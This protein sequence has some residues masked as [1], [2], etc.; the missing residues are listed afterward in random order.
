MRRAHNWRLRDT[1]LGRCGISCT[2]G[3]PGVVM[4]VAAP[5]VRVLP[6]SIGS[7]VRLASIRCLAGSGWPTCPLRRP[8]RSSSTTCSRG[9]GSSRDPRG[10][11]G[12]RDGPASTW[13]TDRNRPRSGPRL[14]PVGRPQLR[15]AF[16]VE[17]GREE[18]APEAA[19]TAR[20]PAGS[21]HSRGP[22]NGAGTQDVSP[23]WCPSGSAGSPTEGL[24]A[25][26][27]HSTRQESRHAGSR[28]S[29]R[30]SHDPFGTGQCGSSWS[31]REGEVRPQP[32]NPCNGMGDNRANAQVQGSPLW[33]RSGQRASLA[34][35]CR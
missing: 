9:T 15:H 2:S 27:D 21:P 22:D 35:S 32:L 24:A 23:H 16:A 29:T 12:S 5:G 6:R 20:A 13:T 18:P 30:Q 17:P 1:P 19:T 34:P 7:F 8:S 31:K 28:R 26:G 25:Q 14:G 4:G 33:R 11:Q 3:T 10:G